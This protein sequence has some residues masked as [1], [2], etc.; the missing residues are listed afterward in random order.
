MI[1]QDP[2]A[3]NRGLDLDLKIF[4]Q[5]VVGPAAA[6]PPLS[7]AALPSPFI[8]MSRI[9]TGPPGR[10]RV[11]AKQTTVIPTNVGITSSNRLIR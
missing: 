11:S 7:A 6:L 9:S 4:R 3:G 1:P 8:R 10:K 2:L 5:G